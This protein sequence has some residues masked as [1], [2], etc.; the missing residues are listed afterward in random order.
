VC[1]AKFSLCI[2]KYNNVVRRTT[3]ACGIMGVQCIHIYPIN[4]IY[5][6]FI[7]ALRK[8]CMP[9]NDYYSHTW[10]NTAARGF[11]TA[12]QCKLVYNNIIPIR[13]YCNR[14]FFSSAII[15][16]RTWADICEP[17][18]PYSTDVLAIYAYTVH[19]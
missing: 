5:L 12:P 18:N 17:T 16:F 2:Y 10:I 9:P 3:L 14:R 19:L 13:T 4:R 6:M 7:N 11:Y 1:T 8:T 15:R